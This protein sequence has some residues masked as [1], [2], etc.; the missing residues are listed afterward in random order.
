MQGAFGWVIVGVTVIAA[1]VAVVT[2]GSARR[3]Y[4][5]IGADGLNDGS[6]RRADEPTGGAGLAAVRDDEIR[7][8]LG[9]RNARRARQGKA[10]LDVE[11]EL[12]ALEAAPVPADPGLV[13][14][15]REL[16]LARNRRRVKQGKEPL[17]V[18]EEVARQLRDLG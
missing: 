2:L 13:A 17:A 11:A 5:R 3:A 7:Q 6:D 14:E 18:E 1:I 9:A 12:R 10:P 15:V 4:D 16:V 8:M